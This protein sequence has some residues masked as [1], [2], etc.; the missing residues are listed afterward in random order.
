MEKLRNLT[1]LA[2]A[3]RTDMVHDSQIAHPSCAGLN[4]RGKYAIVQTASQS[5]S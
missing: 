5:V 3:Q 1:V 4:G 2:Q